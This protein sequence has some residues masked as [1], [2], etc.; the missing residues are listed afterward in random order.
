MGVS[1][2][3]LRGL[4]MNERMEKIRE[5]NKAMV[6]TV[7]VTPANDTMRRLLKHPRAWGFGKEGSV[8]WPDDRFTQRRLNDGD[9]TREEKQAKNRPPPQ[10]HLTEEEPNNAA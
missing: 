9:I 6:R 2:A 4:R 1:K 7:R 10:H 3:S 8:E 5:A